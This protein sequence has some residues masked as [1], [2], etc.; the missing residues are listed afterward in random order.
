MPRLTQEQFAQIVKAAAE[1]GRAVKNVSVGDYRVVV[2]LLTRSGKGVIQWVFE[3]DEV[4][5]N[6]KYWG[7]IASANAPR[8]FGDAIRQAIKAITRA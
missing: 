3:F 5:G 1:G 4:T 8:F 2:D 6:Y 7:P